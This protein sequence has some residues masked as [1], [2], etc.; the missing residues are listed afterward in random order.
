MVDTHISVAVVVQKMIQ[1]EVSGI[2]FTVHPVTEDQ[3]Q[4]LIEACW[5]L[6]E[7]IVGGRVTPDA[8]VI[9][10]RD[11]SLIHETISEQSLMLTRTSAGNREVPVSI[12]KRDG[13]KL[14][15]PHIGRLA[16][17]CQSIETHYDF[18]CDIEWAMEKGEFYIVQSRP[19]TTLGK[20]MNTIN[21]PSGLGRVIALDFSRQLQCASLSR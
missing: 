16:E 19:I 2:T 4:M 3:N 6:G 20:H 7:L 14:S 8:Y 12:S 17:I 10:K 15:M 9:D 13:R 18:P 5:G 1:S 11:G 21:I